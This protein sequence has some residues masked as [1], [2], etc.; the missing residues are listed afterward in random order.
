MA[1]YNDDEMLSLFSEFCLRAKERLA[2]IQVRIDPIQKQVDELNKIIAD[3]AAKLLAL[4]TT[5]SW[6]RTVAT[7]NKESDISLNAKDK[8]AGLENELS[9]LK[10]RSKKQRDHVSE[11]ETT[12]AENE[13]F[14]VWSNMVPSERK[15][16][17]KPAL[18]VKFMKRESEELAER[19]K[20]GDMV[21]I[22]LDHISPKGQERR[23]LFYKRHAS[24][25]EY[26]DSYSQYAG[27]EYAN[28]AQTQA[29][30]Y[31]QAQEEDDYY[32]VPKK[33]P[34]WYAKY[35]IPLN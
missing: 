6:K 8:L 14:R 4:K 35:N 2:E 30:G 18:L 11:L 3:E 33:L 12:I 9:I 19:I 25:G 29:Q 15:H 20:K 31:E 10:D 7:S 23:E 16:S 5:N 27:E 28:E 32:Y 21:S 24:N 22:T 26:D 13:E 17:P 1:S 34:W